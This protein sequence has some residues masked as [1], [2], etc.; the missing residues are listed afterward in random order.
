VVLVPRFGL[1][2]A[3]IALAVGLVCAQTAQIVLAARVVGVVGVSTDLLVVLAC[4]A[5]AL[6]AGRALY[7]AFDASLVVRFATSIVV[8]AVVYAISAWSF[9]M[10][11]D[12]RSLIASAMRRF[13]IL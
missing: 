8:A 4:A 6:G 7:H 10:T 3:A 13:R 9:A 12:D 1:L 5:V 11:R 2:G